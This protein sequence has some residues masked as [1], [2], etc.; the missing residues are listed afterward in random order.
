MTT[1]IPS[2]RSTVTQRSWVQIPYGLKLFSGLIFT[3]TKI[4]LITARIAFILITHTTNASRCSSNFNNLGCSAERK[5]KRRKEGNKFLY[6]SSTSIAHSLRHNKYDHKWFGF[7][8]IQ[9]YLQ[10][11]FYWH[12]IENYLWVNSI[13]LQNTHRK[14][15]DFR[16]TGYTSHHLHVTKGDWRV[17]VILYFL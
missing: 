6:Q 7:G 12:E 13:V 8:C 4:A 3:T 5:T 10:K 2:Q 17:S 15:T 16:R 11:F 14:Q 9:L 1:A